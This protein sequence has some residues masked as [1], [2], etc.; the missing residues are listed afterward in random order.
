MTQHISCRN[1]EDYLF[2]TKFYKQ[3][4]FSVHVLRSFLHVFRRVQDCVHTQHICLCVQCPSIL[5]QA[6]KRLEG[7]G[8]GKS[9]VK[10]LYVGSPVLFTYGHELGSCD[11][12]EEQ[13]QICVSLA[14]L[15]ESLLKLGFQRYTDS[16][17]VLSQYSL[18]V[19][20]ALLLSEMHS[21]SG[22]TLSQLALINIREQFTTVQILFPELFTLLV[23]IVFTNHQTCPFYQCNS[24]LTTKPALFTSVIIPQNNAHILSHAL[25][26]KLQGIGD[27]GQGAVNGLLFVLLTK[28]TRELVCSCYKDDYRHTAEVQTDADYDDRTYPTEPIS[29]SMK[30]YSKL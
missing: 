20:I 14:R 2:E 16:L 9:S 22:S 19:T 17:W 5:Y 12:D 18:S 23:I 13:L 15:V 1:Q 6:Y 3:F 25:C 27:S 29:S 24:S 21:Q 10:I 30:P 4:Y 11:H 26:A 8:E 7:E 28:R